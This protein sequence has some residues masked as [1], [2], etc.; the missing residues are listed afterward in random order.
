MGQRH[1]VSDVMHRPV[2]R[3]R[4]RVAVS[5]RR[6][7]QR[8]RCLS[9]TVRRHSTVGRQTHLL[10]G[11]DHRPILQPWQHRGVRHGA[12][13]ARHRLWP[14]VCVGNDYDV[15][16]GVAGVNSALFGQLFS[17]GAAVEPVSV[18]VVVR[19]GDVH[20]LVAKS[21]RECNRRLNGDISIVGRSVF[22]V[23]SLWFYEKSLQIK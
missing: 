19:T 11:N 6:T 22:L 8:W 18:G 4:Q 15:L 13:D 14:G 17:G 21:E 16:C 12:H 3:S 9:H 10:H 2:R 1:R 20:G 7:G 5:L 23:T